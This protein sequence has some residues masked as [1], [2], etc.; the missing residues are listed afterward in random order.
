MDGAAMA[1]MVE[2]HLEPPSLVWR[3]LGSMLAPAQRAGQPDVLSQIV[4]G[5]AQLWA[6][7]DNGKPVAAVVTQI[8]L[9]PEKRCLLWQVGGSR[10]REW[11]ADFLA[12]L[13]PWARAW[14]CVAIWGAGRAGW[15]RIVKAF[16]GVRIDD[17]D[18]LETWE[19]RI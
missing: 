7:V 12:V 1:M 3:E 4:E 17:V 9:Q 8:T 18:G 13:E 19:R 11:A 15:A 6:V 16:G 14:G 10:L 2:L 5:W